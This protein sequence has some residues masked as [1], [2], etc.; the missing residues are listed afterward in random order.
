M[1]QAL[2]KSVKHCGT[3]ILL[4]LSLVLL[5][6]LWLRVDGSQPVATV[7]SQASPD[8]QSLLVPSATTHHE[9]RRMS[10]FQPTKN[11]VLQTNSLG[12]RG[13]LPVDPKP[14]DAIRILV[15]GDETVL[16][17]HLV[18]DE[19]MP[20]RIG[21]FFSQ[22]GQMVE[23]INGGVPG[24]SPLLSW[25]QYRH[26][27]QRL[28]PDVVVL[29]FD[30]SDVADDAKYRPLLKSDSDQQVCCN[31]LLSESAGAVHRIA[32][33]MHDSALCGWFKCRSGALTNS[34]ETNSRL[35][36]EQYQWTEA[37]RPDLRLPIRHALEPI[38]K[39]RD[40]AVRD[41][42]RL[43]LSTSP[44]PWQTADSDTFPSLS[45][46]IAVDSPWPVTEDLP[47]KL[48]KAMCEKSAVTFCDSTQSFRQYSQPE[49]LFEPDGCQLSRYGAALYARE[50]TITLLS[51]QSL[52]TSKPGA[53]IH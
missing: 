53:A 25:L 50:I 28:K 2:S 6:E 34:H 38:E 39:F 1:I 44:V 40:A 41:G 27:L 52:I 26:E 47:T 15:L 7:T 18:N 51:V 21:Q 31:A 43:V 29:H 32:G 45:R 36:R 3:A 35:L 42:F 37:G 16:G 4:L 48:L 49:K 33:L 13:K 12:L 11:V 5:A 30:M 14:A 19:T 46:S 22:K 24:F 17:P 9:M 8:F 23:V 10:E 20:S